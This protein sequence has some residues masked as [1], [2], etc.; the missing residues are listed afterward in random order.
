M[1]KCTQVKTSTGVFTFFDED[2]TK[3]E[4]IEKCKI[5]NQ[6]LAPVT[7]NEDA[8]ALLKAYDPDNCPIHKSWKNYHVG[9]DLFTFDDKVVKIFS[10]EVIWDDA[11]HDP[12]YND[13]TK[14]YFRVWKNYSKC[15][16]VF[17]DIAPTHG[18]KLLVVLPGTNICSTR[19]RYVCLKPSSKP[20][21]SA[22]ALVEEGGSFQAASGALVGFVGAFVLMGLVV[23]AVKLMRKKP[24]N[25]NENEPT[26]DGCDNLV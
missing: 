2:V 6:I 10:N 1:D 20:C 21:G 5:I 4:A 12:L 14:D 9:L 7:N 13:L 17:L 8:Q 24:A 22:S 18:D 26:L 19:R 23:L 16:D 15:P 3:G 25:K 11:K